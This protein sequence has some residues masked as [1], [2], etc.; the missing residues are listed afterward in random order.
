MMRLADPGD[1]GTLIATDFPVSTN[2]DE[3]GKP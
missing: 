3:G 2:V 1:W